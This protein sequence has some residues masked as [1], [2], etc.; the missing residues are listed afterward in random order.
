[1]FTASQIVAMTD[2]ELGTYASGGYGPKARG[3]MIAT[4]RRLALA[5]TSHRDQVEAAKLSIAERL[6]RDYAQLVRSS[7]PVEIIPESVA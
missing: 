6:D 4:I 2:N 1:M 3:E 7:G 5:E